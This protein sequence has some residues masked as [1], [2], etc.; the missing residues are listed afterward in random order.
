MTLSL[1]RTVLR[2]NVAC[3]DLRG[4]CP[5]IGGAGRLKNGT[6]AAIGRMQDRIQSAAE[7]G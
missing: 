3:G 5:D 4:I 7:S 1:R 6:A 2:G